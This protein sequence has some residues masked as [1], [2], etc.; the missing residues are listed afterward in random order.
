MVHQVLEGVNRILPVRKVGLSS[1]V[2]FVSTERD[3]QTRPW[4]SR[5]TAQ[6]APGPGAAE[7]RREEAEEEEEEVKIQDVSVL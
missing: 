5:T 4:T 6:T 1:S 2:H 3:G 7:R